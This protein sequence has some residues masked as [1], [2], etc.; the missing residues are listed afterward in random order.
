[1]SSIAATPAAFV[2]NP[3]DSFPGLRKKK[4]LVEV[5]CIAI[6]HPGQKISNRNF[7]LFVVSAD[8]AIISIN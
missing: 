8:A 7:N 6:R 3:L 5:H 2:I 1:V 4:L